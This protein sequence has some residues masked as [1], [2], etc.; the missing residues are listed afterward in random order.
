MYGD[1]YPDCSAT[2]ILT[3][4]ELHISVPA[5]MGTEFEVIVIPL[6]SKAVDKLNDD[7]QLMLEAYSA[8]IEND[9]E[10]DAVWKKYVIS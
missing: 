1:N 9:H 8:V 10:E 7:E 6:H 2:T 4:G 5:D 3:Q